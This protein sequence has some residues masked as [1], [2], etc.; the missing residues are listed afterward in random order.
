MESRSAAYRPPPFPRS[1][2]GGITAAPPPPYR[3]TFPPG[4][5]PSAH[6]AQSALTAENTIRAR[7][8][9]PRIHALLQTRRRSDRCVPPGETEAASACLSSGPCP[10]FL[11]D[12]SQFWI[13]SPDTPRPA[14]PA[15]DREK[16][17]TAPADNP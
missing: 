1:P 14:G 4:P 5:A 7:P 6:S 13:G 2:A 10:R 9:R 15:T 8:P 11:R 12:Q 16:S 3:Y 17:E